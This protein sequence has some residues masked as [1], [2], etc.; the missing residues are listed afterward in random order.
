VGDEEKS[1]I[2]A[3]LA[4]G[5]TVADVARSMDRDERTVATVVADHRRKLRDDNAD[6]YHAIYKEAATAAAARGDHKPALEWLDRMGA[7][8]ETSRQRTQLQASQIAADAQRD[9]T[10]HLARGGDG[11]GPVVNIGI[12]LPGQLGQG[13]SQILSHSVT[14][15]DASQ[16]QGLIVAGR[17]EPSTEGS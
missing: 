5:R 3:L 7:I 11:H 15:E 14:I 12:G 9:V 6:A 4:V 17:V 2:L 1:D 10:R 8:P 16:K 13:V